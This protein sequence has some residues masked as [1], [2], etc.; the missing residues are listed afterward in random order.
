MVEKTHPNWKNDSD[1]EIATRLTDSI[2]PAVILYLMRL[3]L[4]RFKL[5]FP[6]VLFYVI[7]S[8]EKY[9]KE[10]KE[11]KAKEALNEVQFLS[12]FLLTL[13]SEETRTD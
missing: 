13:T 11:R 9:K 10:R 8:I 1:F 12:L 3:N 5:I 6:N 2:D 4:S 7:F